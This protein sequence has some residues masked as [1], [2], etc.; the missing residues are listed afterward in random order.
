MTKTY[1]AKPV[2]I[3]ARWF[4][5]DAQGQVLGRLATRIATIL[6]GKHR[7]TYTPHLDTGDF[8][9]VINA[10]KFIVTGRKM[11]E[12]MYYRASR[13]PDG[14]TV[15]PLEKMLQTKPA[16]AVRLAV[17]RMLPKTTLGRQMFSKLKVY[18]GPDHPHAA[19]KP[20]P[21]KL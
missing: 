11:K 15:T 20:E 18:A 21:L 7:P 17:K 16:E 12:K 13:Y 3:D 5:I 9:V 14:L 19:Q 6:M 10:E 1:M 8:V 2:D 4:L